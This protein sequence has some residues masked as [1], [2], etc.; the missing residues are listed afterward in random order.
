MPRASVWLMYERPKSP[1]STPGEK[2]DVLLMGRAIQT[3]GSA[4]LFTLLLGGIL[5][6]QHQHRVAG[7]AKEE[8][9]DHRHSKQDDDPLKQSSDNVSGHG[10]LGVMPDWIRHDAGWLLDFL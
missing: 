6:G 9:A 2:T 1:R 5:A 8:E 10:V 4:D 7:V 3:I